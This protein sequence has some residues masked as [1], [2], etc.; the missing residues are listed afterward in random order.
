MKNPRSKPIKKVP[1]RTLEEMDHGELETLLDNEISFAVRGAA[2]LRAGTAIIKCYTCSTSDHWENLDAGHFVSRR[3]RAVRWDFRNIRAQCRLCNRFL[4]GQK[5]VFE[6][7]L[8]KEDPIALADIR[9]LAATYNTSKMPP[10]WLI[11][12]IRAW[13]TKNARLGKKLKTI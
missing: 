4:E 11:E 5:K 10:Q 2:A 9:F 8:A 1:K 6:E 13:R 7:R 12:Q 3:Y